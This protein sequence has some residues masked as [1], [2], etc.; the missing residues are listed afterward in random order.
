VTISTG[1]LRS[2]VSHRLSPIASRR[3]SLRSSWVAT[4]LSSVLT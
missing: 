2:S 4:L 3:L 1:T